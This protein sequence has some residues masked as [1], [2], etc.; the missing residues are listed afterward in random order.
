MNL[1]KDLAEMQEWMTQAE[2]EYLERDFEYKSPEEL[3]SAVEEMKVSLGPS[4]AAGFAVLC[5]NRSGLG[6]P[7]G[8]HRVCM[9]LVSRYE[10][11]ILFDFYS[12]VFSLFIFISLE[13]SQGERERKGL[14][15]VPW[16]SPRLQCQ[17]CAKPRALCSA[18]PGLKYEQL[19]RGVHIHRMLDLKCSFP[20]RVVGLSDGVLTTAMS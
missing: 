3:E 7:G 8:Q 17:V 20:G 12:F 5:V 16:F 1:K 13:G 10:I 2:E 9:F 15:S 4:E 18:A 19:P 14:Y 11:H 6:L